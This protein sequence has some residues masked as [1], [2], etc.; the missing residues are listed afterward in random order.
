M[1]RDAKMISS[2]EDFLKS[3]WSVRVVP[4]VSG[5]KN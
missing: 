4:R 5:G 3:N 1:A 2:V